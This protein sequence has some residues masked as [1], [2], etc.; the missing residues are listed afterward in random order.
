MILGAQVLVYLK[1]EY[2]PFIDDRPHLREGVYNAF[3]FCIDNLSGRPS[4]LII[5]ANGHEYHI[6]VEDVTIL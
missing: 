2:G 1:R 4:S 6:E 5:E 3:V